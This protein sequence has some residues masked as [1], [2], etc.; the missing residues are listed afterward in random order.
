M[1]VSQMADPGPERT[2]GQVD[3]QGQRHQQHIGPR[4]HWC[5]VRSG[6]NGY[7]VDRIQPSMA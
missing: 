7:V 6:V 2:P 5:S 3:Q 1:T 4:E